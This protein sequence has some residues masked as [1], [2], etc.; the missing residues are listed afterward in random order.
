MQPALIRTDCCCWGLSSPAVPAGGLILL[1]SNAFLKMIS[2]LHGWC[3]ALKE[4][5]R[6]SLHTTLVEAPAPRRGV[7]Q[8]VHLPLH[9]PRP[10]APQEDPHLWQ[11]THPGWAAE[12]AALPSVPALLRPQ[13]AG[14]PAAG[15]APAEEQ[16]GG[17]RRGG[18]RG[19]QATLQ[20]GVSRV[21]GFQGPV[22]LMGLQSK[23]CSTVR[24]N[25]GVFQMYLKKVTER[26][27]D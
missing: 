1:P 17:A 2:K 4:P 7:P 24:L 5:K 8:R 27:P 26:K 9:G 11:A 6:L 21:E 13:P 14:L 19:G 12:A 22:H 15:G 23:L 16:G 25:C 18:G 10:S 20:A 3:Q